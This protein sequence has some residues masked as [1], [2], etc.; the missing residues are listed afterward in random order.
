MIKLGFI[1][2]TGEEIDLEGCTNLSGSV[3][4]DYVK[5]Y[6]KN[7]DEQDTIYKKWEEF[8]DHYITGI[9]GSPHI[10]FV[11]KV[12]KWG[13]VGNYSRPTKIVTCTST[14]D[15][16]LSEKFNKLMNEYIK[17]NYDFDFVDAIPYTTEKMVDYLISHG[18]AGL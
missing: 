11:V 16:E 4:L 13:K 1:L 8:L 18:Q 6:I 2:P 17:E 12:L 9:K 15:V 14:T 7:L 3:H 10:D 5:K